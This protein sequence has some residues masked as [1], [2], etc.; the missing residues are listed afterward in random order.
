MPKAWLICY[1][2]RLLFKVLCSSI[3]IT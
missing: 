2:L 3:G 1:A